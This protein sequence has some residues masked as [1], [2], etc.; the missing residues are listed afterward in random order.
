[1]NLGAKGKPLVIRDAV[2]EFESPQAT[3]GIMF[4]GRPIATLSLWR[5]GQPS[6]W[7]K[8]PIVQKVKSGLRIPQPA[9]PATKMQAKKWRQE[10]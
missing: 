5:F 7:G 6:G 1:M 9:K 8:N 2:L 10:D 3:P 4:G